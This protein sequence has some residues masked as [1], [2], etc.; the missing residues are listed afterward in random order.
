MQSDPPLQ[1]VSALPD[2]VLLL[3]IDSSKSLY[4][5]FVFESEVE[6]RF[7]EKLE[8]R[9]DVRFYIKLPPWFKVQTPIGNYNPDWAL[10]MEETDEFGEKG[11]RVYLVRETKSTKALS[12]LYRSEV[13]KLRCGSRH[14]NGALGVDYRLVI[15]A[16]ELPGGSAV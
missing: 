10:V 11:E 9:E 2:D 3:V 13:L 12:E 16:D 6:R 14:F 7:A 8:S 15:S 1:A 4:D 5:R